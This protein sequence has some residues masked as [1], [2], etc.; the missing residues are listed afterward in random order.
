MFSTGISRKMDSKLS[1]QLNFE[2]KQIFNPVS[3]IFCEVYLRRKYLI[4][5]HESA[6]ARLHKQTCSAW[7]MCRTGVLLA[8]SVFPLF[9]W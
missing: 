5:K 1:A 4:L 9:N 3:Y 7:Q 6:G 8:S 2:F